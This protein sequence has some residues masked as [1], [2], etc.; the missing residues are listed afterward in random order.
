VKEPVTWHTETSTLTLTLVYHLSLLYSLHI[1]HTTPTRTSITTA[2]HHYMIRRDS[3]YLTC[4]K[5]LTGSQLSLPHGINK[6]LKCETKNKLMSVIGPV[7][8][9]YHEGSPV[10]KRS[11][12]WEG[13]VEKVGFEPGV[14]GWMSDRWWEQGWW[15]R[16]VDKT[17]LVRLT[18]Q[19]WKLIHQTRW[20]VSKWAIFDFQGKDGWWARKRETD[21]EMRSGYCKEVEQR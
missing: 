18:K 19:I 1:H 11:L 9:H 2:A 12:R 20:C 10:G 17:R 8:S 13:F 6:K 4:S 21:E 16:W 5:K 14:K 3:V 15:E 7:Q